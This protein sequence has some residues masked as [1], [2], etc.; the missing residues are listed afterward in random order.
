MNLKRGTNITGIVGLAILAIST[1]A[2]LF[3]P[4]ITQHAPA[5]LVGDAWADPTSEAWF[6]LDN[7]GRD[8]L[9]RL[10][11][12]GRTTIG[13]AVAITLLAFAIGVVA[14]FT[15]VIAPRWVDM[16]LARSV[17]ILMS[18]PQLILALIVLSVLGTSIPIL[19]ITIAVLTSTRIFRVSRA[20]GISIAVQ[21][22]V[23]IARLRGEG[24]GWIIMR[25]MLP[26]AL[27]PLLAEFG[28][29]FSYTVLLVSS[30]SFLGLGVRPPDADWGSMVRDNIMAINFGGIAPL[31]PATAIAI[32]TVGV[33]LIVD[34]FVSIYVRTH[35]EGL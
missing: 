22:Y 27:P 8:I 26:N 18:I 33:N 7:L 9:S 25:E 17:D 35:S 23:E 4:L 2:C 11:Y 5:D 28:L 24:I 14:G 21:D 1:I 34:W 3:A 29:R 30:L 31:I 12:G 6:G 32:L 13:L 20:V 10:L 19:I 15:A 16:V